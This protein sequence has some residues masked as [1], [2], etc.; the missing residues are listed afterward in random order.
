MKLL[1]R[2]LNKL[3]TSIYSYK[4]NIGVKCSLGKVRFWDCDKKSIYIGN[5]VSILRGTEL[6]AK[7]D[8]PIR[9]GDNTFIDQRCILRPNVNIGKN[10]SIGPNVMLM[11]DSHLLGPSKKRAG[12]STYKK[13]KIGDGCWIGAGSII[14][15]GVSIG[16]GTVIAAGSV[17]T[18]DCDENSLWGGETAKKIKQLEYDGKD[19]G[20]HLKY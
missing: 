7:S 4:F 9:I 17:V 2:I 3:R 1:A 15:G 20:Y 5:N 18:K 19:F 13:I 11:T 8:R 14:L 10:V 6:C 12:Q 16:N